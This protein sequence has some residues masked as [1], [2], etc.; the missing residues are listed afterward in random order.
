MTHQTSSMTFGWREWVSLPDLG[1]N[2]IK[3]KIDT[4]ARSSALHAFFIKRFTNEGTPWVRFGLHPIQ[5]DT[6]V[7]LICAAPIIDERSVRDSGGNARN[8]IFIKTLIKIGEH[9]KLIE[10]NVVPRENMRFRMLLG[11][12]A[13]RHW[14]TVDPSRSYLIGKP[15]QA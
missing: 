11:R 4:G 15:P 1:V 7:E 14:A 13:L 12:T 9:E 2:Q 10:V 6:K 5:L 3:A 8:R